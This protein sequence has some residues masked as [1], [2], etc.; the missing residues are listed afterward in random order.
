MAL[1]VSETLYEEL[2]TIV[3]ER[4]GGTRSEY[5]PLFEDM[6]AKY[7]AVGGKRMPALPIPADD[8]GWKDVKINGKV[9]RR[10]KAYAAATAWGKANGVKFGTRSATAT[11]SGMFEIILR[12]AS[13][14]AIKGAAK[15]K[16]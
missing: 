10:H 16:A 12:E 2:P 9:E 3:R 1:K 11:E 8:A 13:P 6:L 4:A 7:V 5:V 14:E 15:A